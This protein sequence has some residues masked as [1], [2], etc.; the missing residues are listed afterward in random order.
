MVQ[1]NL[2]PDVKIEYIKA[3][4]FKRLVTLISMIVSGSVIAIVVVLAVVAYGVQGAQIRSLNSDIQKSQSEIAAQNEKVSIDK[5]LTVQN[6]LNSLDALHAQKPILSRV[7]DYMTKVVPVRAPIS[8]LTVTTDSDHTI[9]IKG[10]TDTVESVNVFADTLKFSVYKATADAEEVFAF[11]NVVLA[12]FSRD[13]DG[14]TYVLTM[15]YD[16]VIFDALNDGKGLIVPKKT[17]TRSETERPVFQTE[18]EKA[19]NAPA[20]E[21]K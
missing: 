8:R 17:T 10:T 14:A 6:Q 13:K 19:N 16:P 5:I 9:E 1:F 11:Q 18:S 15:N 21:N 12:S 20:T 7:F 4:R 3:K 2:L